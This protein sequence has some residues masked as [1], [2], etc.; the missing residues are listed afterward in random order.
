MPECSTAINGPQT[1]YG[2]NTTSSSDEIVTQGDAPPQDGRVTTQDRVSKI[3]MFD[4][5]CLIYLYRVAAIFS[6]CLKT[7]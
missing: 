3:G 1:N 4:M 6:F 5:L 7:C 2:S